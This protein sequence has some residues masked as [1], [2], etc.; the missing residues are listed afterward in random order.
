M[1]IQDVRLQKQ[2]PVLNFDSNFWISFQSQ[3]A[4]NCFVTGGEQIQQVP[5]FHQ[6]K[7][8]SEFYCQHERLLVGDW[9]SGTSCLRSIT[10]HDADEQRTS[11]TR[12]RVPVRLFFGGE[13]RTTAN[14]IIDAGSS[15]HMLMRSNSSGETNPFLVL[16]ETCFHQNRKKEEDSE[17]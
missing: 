3:S 6:I 8:H 13:R 7:I 12:V 4:G 9:G 5:K 11:R 17:L 2:I 1:V 10:M 15:A 16:W 14:D